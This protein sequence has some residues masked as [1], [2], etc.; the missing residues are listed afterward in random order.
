MILP[1]PC[2]GEA[3]NCVATVTLGDELLRLVMAEHGPVT[4]SRAKAK[5]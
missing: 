4:R 3:K 5:R 2:E 1:F